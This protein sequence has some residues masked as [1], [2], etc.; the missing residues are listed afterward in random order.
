MAFSLPWGNHVSHGVFKVL[1]GKHDRDITEGPT[2]LGWAVVLMPF[3]MAIA[4]D[5]SPVRSCV[6]ASVLGE[7]RYLKPSRIA[8]VAIKFATRLAVEL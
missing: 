5:S 1:V 2:S 6:P 8:S 4:D 7:R 3:W